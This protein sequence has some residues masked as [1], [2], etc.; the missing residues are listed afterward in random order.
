MSGKQ[1]EYRTRLNNL[2]IAFCIASVL[3][4]SISLLM[5]SGPQALW[6]F[7]DLSFSVSSSLEMGKSSGF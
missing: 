2:S 6:D 1:P 5:L 4:L 7:N 3:C